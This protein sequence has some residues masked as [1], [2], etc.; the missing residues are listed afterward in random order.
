MPVASC[1]H[2]ANP[3]QPNV[4][5]EGEIP[6]YK[7]KESPARVEPNESIPPSSPQP[8]GEEHPHQSPVHD[9]AS[10]P[11]KVS[12]PSPLRI[13]LDTTKRTS[14]VDPSTVK[15]VSAIIQTL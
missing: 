13:S 14:D 11:D 9:K 6:Q 5:E 8:S 12:A 7:H 4:S 2:E 3:S 15:Y 1:D 10:M